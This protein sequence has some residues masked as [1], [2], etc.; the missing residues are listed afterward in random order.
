[1]SRI[2]NGNKKFFVVLDYVDSCSTE[3]VPYMMGNLSS[4]NSSSVSCITEYLKETDPV[5]VNKRVMDITKYT[6]EFEEAEANRL[7]DDYLRS[8]SIDEAINELKEG[9][10]I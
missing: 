9:M 2:D 7:T 1:V 3:Y 10:G 5:A 4:G 6:R 8:L